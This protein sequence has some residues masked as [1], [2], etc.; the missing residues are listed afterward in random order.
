MNSFNSLQTIDMQKP[1]YYNQAFEIASIED[2]YSGHIKDFTSWMIRKQLEITPESIIAY[3]T[4]LNKSEYSAT[5]KN[6]KRQAVKSRIRSYYEGRGI[7]ETVIV[8]TFLKKLDKDPATKAAKVN[9]IAVTRDMWLSPD[10]VKS[11]IIIGRSERQKLFIEF[12]YKSGCRCNEMCTI[13]LSNCKTNDN[14]VKIKVKGKGNK[15][16]FIRVTSDLYY[17]CVNDFK[18]KKYLFETSGGK[19]YRPEYVSNQIKKLGKLIN[20][21]ISAHTMRHS[22]AMEMIRMFPGKLD[23]ISK[24]LGHSTPAITLSMYC[25]TQVDDNDIMKLEL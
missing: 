4:E 6:V 11:L 25:H 9:S 14:M 23:A 15:D 24:Y 5:T 19:H 7:A 20:K 13:L 22:H 18:G 10:Q 16:R 1:L 21:N 2:N 8:D 12:L 17:R 3:I